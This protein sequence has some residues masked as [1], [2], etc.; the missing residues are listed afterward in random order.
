[1]RFSLTTLCTMLALLTP[2][3]AQTE[4]TSAI[5]SVTVY[6]DGATVTRRIRVDL[7]QGDSVLQAVDFPPT[8]DP[9]SLRVEGEAPAKLTIAGIDARPPRAE[10]PPPDP[11]L[12]DRIEALRDD[13]ARLDGKIAAAA[14]RRKFAE[15]FAEQAPAGLGEKGEA[16]PLGEWR[17][18]F[19]AVEDEVM[20]ADTAIRDAQIMQRNIDRELARLDAERTA[21]P[22]RK[23]EVRIDINSDAATT[24]TLLVSYTVHGARWSP[25]YDA[26]LDTGG[27]DRKPSLTLVRRAEI[28]QATGEDWR[29][30]DLVVSTVRTAKGGS[31][32]ELRPLV[33]RYPAPLPPLPQGAQLRGNATPPPPAAPQSRVRGNFQQGFAGGKEED[34]IAAEE[35]EATADT[36][37]FQAVYRIPGRISVTASEGAKSF[38]ISST[39]VVPDLL[40]RAVPALDATA[41]LEAS[42]KHAEDAPLLPGRVA[43]Y[44]DGTYVGRGQMAMSPK[45]EDVRLGFGADDHIKVVRSTVRQVEGSAG[46]I[47][48]AKTDRR[49]YK[50]SI[51]NGHDASIRVVIEDQVPVSEI[52]DIKVELLPATTAPTEKDV[53]NRRG[54][55][56]WNLEVGPGETKEI[57]VAWRLRWPADKTIV[58]APGL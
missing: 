12:D 31:A 2:A 49:E 48:S 25:L 36:G 56:A 21:N 15:R 26:R 52:E 32:P 22:P 45:D 20:T 58:L 35:Q 41:F 4:I 43:I 40:V 29:D 18:A 14:A 55:M 23:M 57:R 9:A 10:R 3:A 27:R 13:R 38:R 53:R 11:A 16:R 1:M 28:V 33:V 17:A 8:L 37:G 5:E 19:A 24:A 47:N 42:F 54:V 50:T 46:M 6:P 51:R 44:R 39:V 34:K 30:V 7:P